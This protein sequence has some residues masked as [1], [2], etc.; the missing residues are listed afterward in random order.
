MLC[1]RSQ[2]SH[3]VCIAKR[4]V[5]IERSDRCRGDF[6]WANNQLLFL[7]VIILTFNYTGLFIDIGAYLPIFFLLIAEI[8]IFKA[9]DKMYHMDSNIYYR[10]RWSAYAH[11][12]K[13]ST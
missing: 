2:Q 3:L 13:R 5:Q 7:F 4:H 1:I 11:A 9:Q 10:A 12:G 6:T 8:I